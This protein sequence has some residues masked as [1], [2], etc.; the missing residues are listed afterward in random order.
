MGYYL[1]TQPKKKNPL[2]PLLQ[3][4]KVHVLFF[5]WFYAPVDIFFFLISSQIYHVRLVIA[6][7][8]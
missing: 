5:I 2:F 4:I 6:L 3:R 8:S 7:N 1:D